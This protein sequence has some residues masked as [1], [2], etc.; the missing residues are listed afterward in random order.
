MVESN[1]SHKSHQMIEESRNLQD[2][3]NKNISSNDNDV[4][5]LW[6]RNIMLE[7]PKK[8]TTTE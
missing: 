5:W 2:D 7:K 4:Q 3:K 8:K 1:R 6:A